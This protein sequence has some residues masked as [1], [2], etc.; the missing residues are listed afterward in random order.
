MSYY[1]TGE[2]AKLCDVSVR[3]VQYYDTK[4]ILSPSEI[5]EGGRRLYSDEDLLTLQLICTLKSIG[6]SLNGIRKILDSEFS[7]NIVTLLLNDHEK[8]LNQEI[9]VRQKQLEMIGVVKSNMESDGN[10]LKKIL[11]GMEDSVEKKRKN[12]SHKKLVLVYLAVGIG[13][14]SQIPLLMWLMSLGRWWALVIYGLFAIF[15]LSASAVQLKNRVFVCSKCQ[16]SFNPTLLRKFFT[17]GNHKVRWCTCPNC[18]NTDWCVL[19]EVEK[20]N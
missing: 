13:V 17:T 8:L 12:K 19:R 10:S 15:G 5:S 7:N 20:S 11:L 1:T 4:G 9:E 6:L 2:L 16:N 18:H 3:T 14:L